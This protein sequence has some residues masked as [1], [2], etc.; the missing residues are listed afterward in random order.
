M[1][2]TLC[3]DDFLGLKAL[4]SHGLKLSGSVCWT[5]TLYPLGRSQYRMM[6]NFHRNGFWKSGKNLK[7]PQSLSLSHRMLVTL[8]K[9]QTNIRLTGV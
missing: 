1:N 8:T 5:N 7:F 4:S 6:S 3:I 2:A 9:M